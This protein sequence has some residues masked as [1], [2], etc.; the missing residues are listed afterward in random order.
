MDDNTPSSP[1]TLFSGAVFRS[2]RGFFV[3]AFSREVGWGFPLEAEIAAILHATLFAFEWGWH[4]LWVESDSIL[5]IQSLQR[6]IQ[7]V[8]WRLQG[9]WGRT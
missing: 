5:T 1:G 4:S 7:L 9:L 8:P 3:A 6:S 2:S